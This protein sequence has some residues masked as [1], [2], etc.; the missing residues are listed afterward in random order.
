MNKRIKKLALAKETLSRL[1]EKD[2]GW[3]AG[4]SVRNCHSVTEFVDNPETNCNYTFLYT[5]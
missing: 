2:L 1:Q 3:A 4:D 5:C